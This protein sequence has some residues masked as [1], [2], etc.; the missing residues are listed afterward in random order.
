MVSRWHNRTRIGVTESGM[1]KQNSGSHRNGNKGFTLI[2]LLVVIAIIAIL[3]SILFPVFARA[4]ENARRT[5]CLSNLKQIGLGIMQYTQ[6]YD[7]TYP[8]YNTYDGVDETAPYWYD[9]VEPYLKSM[10]VLRCPSSRTASISIGHYGANA[11]LIKSAHGIGTSYQPS[12]KLAEVN[13][14]AST[15]MV[16]DSGARRVIP[17]GATLS[18]L[19]GSSNHYLPGVGSFKENTAINSAYQDD[20]QNGR[21][22]LGVNV[23]FADGHAKWVQSS[24]VYREAAKCGTYCQWRSANKPTGNS[25]F[26]PYSPSM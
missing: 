24:T 18:V 11:M 12:P 14:P 21:H 2:E 8:N 10:E 7:E 16:M 3:A 26:S 15:Y 22:F 5:S 23:T 9:M 17:A 6:D 20:Y 25:A 19:N 4:R 13:F 1:R